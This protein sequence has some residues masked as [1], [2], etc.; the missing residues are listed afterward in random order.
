MK[1]NAHGK[2]VVDDVQIRK[3]QQGNTH[4]RRTIGERVRRARL[5][6]MRR[7]ELALVRAEIPPESRWTGKKRSGLLGGSP[8]EVGGGPGVFRGGRA[9]RTDERDR[10]GGSQKHTS[11]GP[12]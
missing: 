9:I 2:L 10:N 5:H 8:T 11:G 3:E 12:R 1:P 6:K 4:W 7:V